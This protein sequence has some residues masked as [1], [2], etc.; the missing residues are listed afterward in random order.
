MLLNYLKLAIR[1]L[2]RNPFFTFI[3]VFGLSVGVTMFYLLWQYA[4]FELKSDQ[5]HQ[6][7]QRIV[8]TGLVD[9]GP[10]NRVNLRAMIGGQHLTAFV[11]QMTSM[12][13]KISH[14]STQTRRVFAGGIP[15]IKRIS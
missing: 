6:D 4:Q 9:K 8:R 14:E 1:L 10:T 15:F 5:F 12:K 7:Y 13:S 11:W 2:L 3:N